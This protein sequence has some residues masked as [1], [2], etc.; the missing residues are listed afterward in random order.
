MTPILGQQSPVRPKALHLLFAEHSAPEDDFV[1][2]LLLAVETLLVS[3]DG[4]QFSL[5]L[6]LSSPKLLGGPYKVPK[7]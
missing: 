2:A 4:C 6:I 3:F 7:L 1:L 5:P